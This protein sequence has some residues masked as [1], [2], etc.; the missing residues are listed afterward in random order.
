MRIPRRYPEVTDRR[1]LRFDLR[2]ALVFLTCICILLGVE[3]AV[4]TM[5]FS[6]QV[7][8]ILPILTIGIALFSVCGFIFYGRQGAIVIGLLAMFGA[9]IIVLNLWGAM[10]SVEKASDRQ[11]VPANTDQK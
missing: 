5:W 8:G 3:I 10:R 11:K 6:D 9:C 2:T 1:R 7:R 4:E